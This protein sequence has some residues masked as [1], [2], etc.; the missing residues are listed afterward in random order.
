MRNT[1]QPLT[2]L[3]S[4]NKPDEWK[5]WLNHIQ[6]NLISTGYCEG[7]TKSGATEFASSFLGLQNFFSELKRSK[8]TKVP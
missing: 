8:K 7:L 5:N 6:A 1:D 2:D 3:L 4:I